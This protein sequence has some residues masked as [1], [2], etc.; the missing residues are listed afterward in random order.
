MVKLSRRDGRFRLKAGT[1]ALHEKTEALFWSAEGFENVAAYQRFLDAMR[2]AHE[3]FG[4]AA[5][6]RLPHAPGLSDEP[7]LIDALRR[8]GA[9]RPD[10]EVA[11]PR[12][13]A[14]AAWGAAY[15]LRGSALG[16]AMILRSPSLRPAWPRAYLEA[17]AQQARNGAVKRFFAAMEAAQPDWDEAARGAEAVFALI[18]DIGAA[19]PSRDA[20]LSLDAAPARDAA[21]ACDAAPARDAALSRN[22]APSRDAAPSCEAAPSSRT[23]IARSDPAPSPQAAPR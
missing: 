14:D 22:A 19:A 13:S 20:A 18:H 1:A 15:A 10:P 21:P 5:A 11:P 23:T 2:A 9:A 7:A 4:R 6:A 17:S 8:D 3:R 12:R 16:A